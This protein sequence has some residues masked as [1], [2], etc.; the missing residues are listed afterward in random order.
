MLLALVS[1]LACHPHVTLS[2]VKPAA[3]TLPAEIG[4]VAVVNRAGGDLSETA[5]HAVSDTLVLSP[6]LKAIDPVAGQAALAVA[7]GSVV[8]E[9][10]APPVVGKICA[11]THSS[12]VVSLDALRESGGW[13]VKAE[14]HDVTET[15]SV[16]DCETCEPHDVTVTRPEAVFKATW[17]GRVSA[18]WTLQACSGKVVDHAHLSLSETLYG[19]GP[20][21][22][23][24][25]SAAGD[26]NPLR[27]DMASG[28][29]SAYA[30]RIAPMPTTA[31][32]RYYRGSGDDMLAGHAAAQAGDWE[33]ALK[34]WTTAAKASEGKDK[35]KAQ[36]D[37]A[38][39][40]EAQGRVSK[41]AV[42][43]RLARKNLG[44]KK[45]VVDYQRTLKVRAGDA[46]VL[47]E[48]MAP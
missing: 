39:A 27:A 19:E 15:H 12:G 41:A 45:L 42:W 30:V 48:Q 31:E 14:L 7:G 2:Y 1:L 22:G 44:N 5:S 24:A 34:R 23:D 16:K 37:V 10:L 4:A 38:L 43:T 9:P 11:T 8:G 32:R 35:G 28:L 3:V 29:G 47:E 46:A 40:N 13:E 36:L 6:R 25:R 20:T 21:D 18:D 26:P 33:T 17:T